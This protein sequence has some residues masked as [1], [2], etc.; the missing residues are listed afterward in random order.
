MVGWTVVAAMLAGVH[1]LVVDRLVQE[2]PPAPSS[3]VFLAYG[4]L[5]QTWPIYTGRVLASVPQRRSSL[6]PAAF[7]F[8]RACLL[9]MNGATVVLFGGLLA[10]YWY[11]GGTY[12]AAAGAAVLLTGLVVGARET[13]AWYTPRPLRESWGPAVAPDGNVASAV[14]NR[15]RSD[16][17]APRKHEA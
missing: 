16:A 2:V 5:C 4:F 9:T 7:A 10:G 8:Y 13:N 14:A 17:T 3:V 6:R 1:M 12:V 15:P 11:P